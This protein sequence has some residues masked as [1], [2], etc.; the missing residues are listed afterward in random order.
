MTSGLC[1]DSE[2]SGIISMTGY[3]S[4]VC[5]FRQLII[6]VVINEYRATCGGVYGSFLPRDWC[7]LSTFPHT[8]VFPAGRQ[9]NGVMLW[10]S[11]GVRLNTPRPVR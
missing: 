7:A 6:E 2:K 3:K 9:D 10:F 1:D 11:Q 5:Y 4:R 8:A